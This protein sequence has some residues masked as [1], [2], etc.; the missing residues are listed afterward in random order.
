MI[1]TKPYKSLDDFAQEANLHPRERKNK[2][3]LPWLQE[4]VRDDVIK[5]ISLRM[6]EPYTLKLKFIAE[7]TPYTQNDFAK[8]A[9][10]KA[11]DAKINEL[12]RL[13]V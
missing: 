5:N 11:I 3:R 8:K 13:D 2:H 12:I 10:E 6:T 4:N 9:V 7:N 1:D